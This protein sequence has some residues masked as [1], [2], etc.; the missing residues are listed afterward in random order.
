MLAKI[1]PFFPPP[2][3]LKSGRPNACGEKVNLSSLPTP[4]SPVDLEP[5]P[6]PPR[7]CCPGTGLKPNNPASFVTD[8]KSPSPVSYGCNPMYVK[9]I[10]PQGSFTIEHSSAYTFPSRIDPY[11]ET[12]H[13]PRPED[14][15]NGSA[16]IHLSEGIPE[17]G[18]RRC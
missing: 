10:F 8:I 1:V 17:A 7:L 14:P 4:L 2:V 3:N 16:P 15:Q 9:S 12:H 18:L 13:T 11:L 5:V 6:L